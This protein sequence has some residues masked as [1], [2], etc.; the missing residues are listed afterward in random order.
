MT[1]NPNAPAG[2]ATGHGPERSLLRAWWAALILSAIL[3]SLYPQVDLAVSSTFHTEAGFRIAQS[4]AYAR[5]RSA[6]E[7]LYYAAALGSLVGFLLSLWRGTILRSPRRIWGTLTAVWLLGPGLI[8]NGILK[9][10]WGRA[11]PA[12]LAEFGGTAEFTPA[13][14]PADQCA[15][16]CSFVSGEAAGAAA[17]GVTLWLLSAPIGSAPLRFALRG[18]AVAIVIVGALLR[19]I[20]GRHFLSDVIFAVIIVTGLALVLLHLTGRPKKETAD[21]AG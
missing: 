14:L 3:F 17:F 15:R 1:S 10:Y 9:E 11:R 2:Q 5:A 16:N 21:A 20:A 6:M 8:V 12:H 19:V 18:V 13:L 7:H 4:P